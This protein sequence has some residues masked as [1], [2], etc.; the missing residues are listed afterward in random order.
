MVEKREQLVE[1]LAQS[2]QYYGGE[3]DMTLREPVG[4][5]VRFKELNDK[6]D[7]FIHLT[8]NSIH[9]VGEFDEN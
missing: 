3:Y 1:N 5:D 8:Q 2:D 6:L 7:K 9:Y 4:E